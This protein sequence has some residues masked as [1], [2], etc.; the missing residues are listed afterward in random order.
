MDIKNYTVR[1]V[2][3]DGHTLQELIFEEEKNAVELAEKLC[4]E[5]DGT[6]VFIEYWRSSDGQRGYLNR[7]GY[8]VT[9]RSWS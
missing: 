2:S 6:M 9:G 1:R 8:A 3:I 4:A 5:P 7:D